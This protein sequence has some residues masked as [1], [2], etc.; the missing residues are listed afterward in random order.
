VS[1][2]PQ[3]A[4]KFAVTF[5]EVI[6]TELEAGENVQPVFVGVTVYVP[7]AKPDIA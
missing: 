1:V 7:G 2:E 5:A 4:V 6:V 3:E